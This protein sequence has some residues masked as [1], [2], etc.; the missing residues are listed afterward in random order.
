MEKITMVITRLLGITKSKVVCSCDF[1]LRGD[2]GKAYRV[3]CTLC[4]IAYDSTKIF[5]VLNKPYKARMRRTWK[6]ILTYAIEEYWS[7]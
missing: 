1:I 3:S 7:R 2:D 5:G 6:E 4:P